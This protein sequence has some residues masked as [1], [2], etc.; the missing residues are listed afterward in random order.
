MSTARIRLLAGLATALACAACGNKGPLYLPDERRAD[1]APEAAA[2]AAGDEAA[3]APTTGVDDA[4]E[5]EDG[6]RGR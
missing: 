5:T 1:L 4:T 6:A 2:A 3:A